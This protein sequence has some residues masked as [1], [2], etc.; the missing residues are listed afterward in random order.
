[1]LPL[2]FGNNRKPTTFIPDDMRSRLC[3]LLSFPL[4]LSGFQ[5]QA[6]EPLSK[7]DSLLREQLSR[8]SDSLFN[9]HWFAETTGYHK[10][11]STILD[12]IF[13]DHRKK[14]IRVVADRMVAYAP[15]RSSLVDSIE[16]FMRSGIDPQWEGYRIT[17]HSN[18]LDLRDYV[19]NF[20]RD[21]DEVDRSRQL[22]AP[23]KT[24]A[25]L[26]RNLDRS[27]L[28]ES[29]LYGSHLA[30]WHSHGW[31]YEPGLRRWEWQRARLFQT[32]EDLYPM[33]YTLPFLVPMLENAGA[34]V[35]MPRERDIQVREVVVDNDGSTGRSVYVSGLVEGSDSAGRGFGLGR[36]TYSQ[37]NPFRLGSYESMAAARQASGSMQWIP[38]IPENGEYG[39][40]VSYGW[41]ERP[42]EDARYTVHHSGGV[43]EFLVNQA[44]GAGT[45]IYLGTFYFEEGLNPQKGRVALSNKSGFRRATLTGDAVR[46][47]GGM[48]NI[49]REGMTSLRPRYQEGARYYLQYAGFPDTLVWNLNDPIH[50]Y[51][52]DYQSRGEWVSYLMGAPSGPAADPDAPG[53]G[54]PVDLALAFHTDA[55]ITGS[56]TVI[57]TLGIYSTTYRKGPFPSGLSRM[58]SRE[59]CD[60]VQSQIVDDLRSLYDSTWIRRAMWDKAYSEAF[61][62]NVPTMLLELFSH[63][64]F[65]DMRFG[66]DP[67][68]RFHT[69]RAIYKGMLKFLSTLKGTDYVV[70]P[71]PVSHMA[72]QLL[73]DTAIRVSWRPVNDPLE[74]SAMPDHYRV[75]LRTNQG[76]FDTGRKVDTCQFILK[77]I[78]P[79][80]IYSFKVCAVN[81]GGESF[82]SEVL[83]A[84]RSSAEGGGGQ[85][86]VVAAFDRVSGPAWFDDSLHAGFLPLLDEGVPW[87]TDLHTVGHQFDF[88][89]DS[90]WL[91]D[92]APGHGASFADL[93]EVVIPGNTHDFTMIHGQAILSAGFSYASLSD[94]ILE[95]GQWDLSPYLALDYLA[96]EERSTYHS[97]NASGPSHEV[98]P[99]QS[100]QV[101]ESYLNAGG[102]L[103]LSGAHVATDVHQLG[104]DSLV[105]GLLKYRWRNSHASRK[106][107]FYLADP[108][109]GDY[110]STLEFNAGQCM[111]RY[112]VEG[113]DALEPADSTASTFMRYRE[114]NMSAAVAHRG[115][116]RVLSLGFPFESILGEATREELMELF[117]TFLL[118]EK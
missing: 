6:Q 101:L 71:L 84:A 67:M 96:G 107:G 76:G 91:D 12:S 22:R 36:G 3:I 32:V 78:L 69:S 16:H 113:A 61:R 116:Y 60:L 79:D 30:V 100:L 8:K 2:S 82:P 117:M 19:P 109:W 103:L 73:G 46:F 37:E 97:R 88:R 38:E 34:Q 17:V 5:G 15:M 105:A 87:G 77:G 35:L 94:E 48:G 86:A 54:I 42:A 58:T 41:A 64:N 9:S 43:S 14:S 1:M 110:R 11:D 63:Q 56:D 66:Q 33:A 93:E 49:E 99:G 104:Q 90:P 18:K 74:A 106:G 83:S 27:Y 68:F 13:I 102:A 80:S 44:M 21:A 26:V 118:E 81:R 29:V 65:P 45:W 20:Y 47:G 98:F 23:R 55:G 7:P 25:P 95:E 10:R 72:T 108:Q 75:Y 92:D 51:K 39:V 112:A 31:Y 62:P 89:K 114:N 111:D 115:R 40:Y 28:E 57:G 70:Q 50:D 53:L 24:R 4:L 52:D 59:L 85:V